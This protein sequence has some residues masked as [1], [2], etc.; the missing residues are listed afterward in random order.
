ML[1][2]TLE[3]LNFY[4]HLYLVYFYISHSMCQVL[5]NWGTE[6]GEEAKARVQGSAVS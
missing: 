5:R 6:A 1:S 2:Y 3:K 4:V